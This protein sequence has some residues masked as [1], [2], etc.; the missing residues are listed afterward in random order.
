MHAGEREALTMEM[1][2]P[3][4]CFRCYALE[5][6]YGRITLILK[7]LIFSVTCGLF[8][9]SKLQSSAVFQ[10]IKLKFYTSVDQQVFIHMYPGF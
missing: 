9:H 3:I 7:S 8:G 2:V 4:Y 6:A 10:Y 5:T 1:L